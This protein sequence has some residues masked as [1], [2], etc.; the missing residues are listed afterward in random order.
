MHTFRSIA[1]TL[2]VGILQTIIEIIARE[3]VLLAIEKA[4]TNLHNKEHY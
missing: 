2:L 3:T 4:K 1:Q